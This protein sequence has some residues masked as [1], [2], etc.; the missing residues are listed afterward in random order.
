MRIFAVMGLIGL[1]HFSQATA[2]AQVIYFDDH[3][4]A[5]N[6][7]I[8]DA[9]STLPYFFEQAS[10]MDPS[11]T[12]LKVGVPYGEDRKE[13]IWMSYCRAADAGAISCHFANEPE[14]VPYKLGDQYTFTLD[15][16]SDWMWFDDQGFIHGGYTMRVMLPR[17]PEDQANGLRAQLAPL[18]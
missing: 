11:R 2:Q 3:D 5:M 4:P 14:H 18:P 8:I 1:I 13:H 9:R 15:D 6:Q 10:Q 17:L 12:M 16:I 7:A